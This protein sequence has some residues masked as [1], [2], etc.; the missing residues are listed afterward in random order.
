MKLFFFL[1]INLYCELYIDFIINLI[2]DNMEYFIGL[3]L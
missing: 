1:L 3:V 2:Y